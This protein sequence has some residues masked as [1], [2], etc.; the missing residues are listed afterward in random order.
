[1][2]GTG[3]FAA[4]AIPAKQVLV[5]TSIDWQTG[6]VTA[7]RLITATI[8]SQATGTPSEVIARSSS[9]SD[10]GASAGGTVLFPSG[11]P[12]K[13]GRTVCLNV[14]GLSFSVLHGYLTKDK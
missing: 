12:V 9:V 14:D 10:E 5:V 3:S 7:S 2:P 6:G 13:S 1:M 11:I 8:I 4:F